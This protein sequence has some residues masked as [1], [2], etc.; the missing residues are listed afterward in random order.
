VVAVQEAVKRR[1]DAQTAAA[2]K[3]AGGAGTTTPAGLW[4]VIARDATARAGFDL[5]HSARALSLTTVAMADA[6]IC[7]WDAKFAYWTERPITADP[8]LDVLFAT[9]PFPSYTSGHATLSGAAATVLSHLLPDAADS[10]AA[11]ANEAAASRVWAGIHF[12]IDS[13]VGLA[14]GHEIGRL[15]V[16]RAVADGAE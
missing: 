7:C 11:Q 4:T 12:S 6:L 16:A 1:T 10:L 3:W 15:V 8:T 2:L 9:P 5:P 13:D 14:G